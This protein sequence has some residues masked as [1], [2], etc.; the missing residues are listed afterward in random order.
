VQAILKITFGVESSSSAKA[1]RKRK[2]LLSS[3]LKPDEQNPI[4]L[5]TKQGWPIPNTQFPEYEPF[6]AKA[7]L[8]MYPQYAK[9]ADLRSISRTYNCIGMVFG[10]RRTHIEVDHVPHILR[11]DGYRLIQEAEVMAGDLVIYRLKSNREVVHI[12][13]ILAQQT[14]ANGEIVWRILSK[15]GAFGGEYIHTIYN[16]PQEYLNGTMIE[17]WSERYIP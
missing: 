10:N 6:R 15:W 9:I 8:E 5:A 3:P 7:W 16:V 13:L 12:G 17:Y 14:M 2:M 1:H 4:P 11:D